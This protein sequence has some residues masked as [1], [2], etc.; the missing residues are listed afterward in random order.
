MKIVATKLSLA[1]TVSALE[2]LVIGVD[3]SLVGHTEG[4]MNALDVNHN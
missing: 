4:F 1:V 3:R 2:S